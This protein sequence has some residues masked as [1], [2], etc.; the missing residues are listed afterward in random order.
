MGL[1]SSLFTAPL[2]PLKG[3]VWVAERIQEE[4]ERQYYDPGAIR[5]QLEQVAQARTDGELSDEEATAME[6]QLIQRLMTSTRRTR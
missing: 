2:A 6:K 1:I 4:A 5:R 3:T